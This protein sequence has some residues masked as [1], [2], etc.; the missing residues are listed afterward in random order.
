MKPII[1]DMREMTLSKELYDRKPG[2]FFALFIYGLLVLLATA[3]AWAYWG[4]I[5]IVVR[6]QGIIRP[7]AQMA[8]VINAVGGEVRGMYFYEGRRVAAGDVL[9]I[10]DT[11]HLENEYRAVAER[12]DHLRFDLAGLE[13]YRQSIDAGVN[14]VG[15]FNDEMS[16]RFDAFHMNMT[17]LQHGSDNQWQTL[18][19]NERALEASIV[20]AQ[21]ELTVLRAFEASVLQGANRFTTAA[22]DDVHYHEL[23]N[24][25]RNQY[26]HFVAETQ[27]LRL[28]ASAAQVTLAGNQV[29]RASVTGGLSMFA[30]YDLGLY[31]ARFEEYLLAEVQLRETHTQAVAQADTY[32]ALYAAGVVSRLTVENAETAA[33]R[34]YHAIAELRNGYLITLDAAI[35]TEQNRIAQL[36]NQVQ[37]LRTGTL[38]GISAQ[39]LALEA[40]VTAMTQAL[41]QLRLQQEGMFFV[42]Y[43]AGDAAALRL[44]EMNRTLAQMTAIEQDIAQLAL[45]SAGIKSQINDATVRAPIDGIVSV[46]SELTV[47]SFAPG[48]VQV[49]SVIP[50]WDELLNTHIFVNNNDI[51]RLS[52]G[53]TVRYDIAAMPRRDFGDILGT[54]TRISAD[55]SPEAGGFF[56]VEAEIEDRTFYDTRGEGMELRVGMAFEARIVVDRQ[57]ILFYLLDRLNLR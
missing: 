25:Y 19:E 35:R 46:H 40:D 11:F 55:M 1:L 29:L 22:T 2:R 54:V 57:R 39:I 16:T 44:G 20:Q 32:V 24:A 51:G 9:Y 45:S 42:G 49:L 47:G 33:T 34:A 3:L 26:Q 50:T 41:A 7:H 4:R 21:T 36:D 38:A 53:L 13:L 43:E 37:S 52:E 17:A 6:A 30:A 56:I 48:G 31:R 15:A 10:I 28:Q 12:L 27:A 8:L 5:D 18:A 23:R 14:L